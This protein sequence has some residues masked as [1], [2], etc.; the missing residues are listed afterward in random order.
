MM[1]ARAFATISRIVPRNMRELLHERSN[2]NEYRASQLTSAPARS[3]LCELTEANE[4]TQQFTF[5]APFALRPDHSQKTRNVRRELKKDVD[6]FSTSSR[7][8]FGSER[9]EPFPVVSFLRPARP[10]ASLIAITCQSVGHSA[11]LSV[12]R[13]RSL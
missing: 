3:L 5:R 12:T 1:V 7:L 13:C 8:E 4:R 11:D 9:F 6:C 2:A 10:S